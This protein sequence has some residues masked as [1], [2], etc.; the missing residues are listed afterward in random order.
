MKNLFQIL[1][2]AIISI[3]FFH[4]SANA[5]TGQTGAGS[6]DYEY[7]WLCDSTPQTTFYRVTLHRPGFA[8]IVVGNYK[9]DGT[10]YTVTSSVKVGPCVTSGG[11]YPDSSYQYDYLEMCDNSGANPV[12]YI[13]IYRYAT[14]QAT[15]AKT[16]S[17][18]GDFNPAT[19]GSY[20]AGGSVYPGFCQALVVDAGTK[21]NTIQ[22]T[23]SSGTLLYADNAMSCDILNMG[24]NVARL[25][26]NSDNFDLYPGERWFCHKMYDEKTRSVYR[27]PQLTYDANYGAQPTTLHITQTAY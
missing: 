1:F 12:S 15:G 13:K 2:F 19:G 18:V 5:Q 14:F 4:N 7:Q 8:A 22:A 6:F 24:T 23:A 11:A 27:C 25:V 21:V 10:S 26:I 3:A 17:F 16:R 20:T 9:P